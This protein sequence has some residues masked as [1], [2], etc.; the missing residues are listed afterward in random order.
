MIEEFEMLKNVVSTQAD[1]LFNKFDALT[2][3]PEIR[4]KLLTYLAILVQCRTIPEEDKKPLNMKAMMEEVIMAIMSEPQE[5]VPGKIY[6][7]NQP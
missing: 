7:P 4:N 2:T 3:N 6:L 5:K 1:E